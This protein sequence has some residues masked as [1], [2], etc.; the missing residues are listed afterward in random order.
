[1]TFETP[2][3]QVRA[4]GCAWYFLALIVLLLGTGSAAYR[5]AVQIPKLGDRL[6]QVV[7]PGG[8]TMRLT[9]TGTYMIFYERQSVVDGRAYSS[10][11]ISG[12]RISLRDERGER[13]TL[14]SPAMSSTY[15]F[16]GRSGAAI[17]QFDIKQPGAYR[18]SAAYDDGRT[19]P[20]VVLA[21]GT[22]FMAGLLSSI[23]GA[24]ALGFGGVIAAVAIAVVVFVKR[25]RAKQIRMAVPLTRPPTVS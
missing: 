6:T 22:G 4:P 12:L 24:L 21:V 17:F 5:L 19:L 18:L 1:M 3:A 14:S 13:L 25:R 16:G 10:D 15:S 11:S 23:L 9:E 7:V 8:A 20:R 2:S